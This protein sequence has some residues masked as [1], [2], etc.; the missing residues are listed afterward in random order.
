MP[1]SHPPSLLF[2]RFFF[3][4]NG[5]RATGGTGV[6]GTAP[7]KAH[8]LGHEILYLQ[9]LTPGVRT[10]ASADDPK[11]SSRGPASLRI[12]PSIPIGCGRAS[13]LEKMQGGGRRERGKTYRRRPPRAHPPGGRA[14]ARSGTGV[15]QALAPGARRARRERC[16]GATKACV[17]KAFPGAVAFGFVPVYLRWRDADGRAPRLQVPM[18]PRAHGRR[19]PQAGPGR[20]TI[21]RQSFRPLAGSTG[22]FTGTRP[23]QWGPNRLFPFSAARV[24]RGRRGRI[25]SFRRSADGH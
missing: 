5:S 20:F 7:R 3:F 23:Q 15:S 10:R 19:R 21:A 18:Q 25:P 9:C 12:A 24:P 2:P 14:G 16:H 11:L 22:V 13:T 1:W 4:P 6:P 8:R 17:D